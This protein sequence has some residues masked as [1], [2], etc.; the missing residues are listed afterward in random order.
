[1]SPYF[2]ELDVK[3]SIWKFKFRHHREYAKSF[4]KFISQALEK[5][6]S[7]QFEIITSVP[8]SKER[9]SERGYNQTE[10][11]AKELATIFKVKYQRLLKKVKNN[12]EQHTLTLEKRRQ[13]VSGVYSALR[14]NIINGKKILLCDDIIT[15]G[16]TI[17]ECKKILLEAGADSVVCAT[18]ATAKNQKN[19]GNEKFWGQT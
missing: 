11:F 18:I 4:A 7:I 15:T 6:D 13:N 16:N 12:L 19:E 1:M 14:P 5:T 9:T 2:Y 8:I 3:K 17:G 10:L